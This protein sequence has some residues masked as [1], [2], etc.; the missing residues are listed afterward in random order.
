MPVASLIAL[1]VAAVAIALVALFVVG[2][3]KADEQVSTRIVAMLRK[4]ASLAEA[5]QELAAVGYDPKHIAEV[6][7][8]MRY[9]A[10][11]ADA[12]A[13]LDL[14]LSEEEAQK[15]LMGKGMTAE[16]AN[17]VIGEAR[18]IRWAHRWPVL[19]AAGGLLLSAVGIAVCFFGLVLRDGNRTGRFV[20]FP[21]AGTL[22]ISVGVC[23]LAFGC[24]PLAYVFKK[25]G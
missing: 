15:Q 22:T 20:T 16:G 17:E 21:Y 1:G 24:L 11:L 5:Q 9:R 14:G 13:L 25:I 7:E 6:L 10:A 19:K 4:G 23:L 18:L 12:S 3:R 2:G 8:K